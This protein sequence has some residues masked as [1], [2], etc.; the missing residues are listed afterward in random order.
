MAVKKKGQ[1][2]QSSEQI[3][4]R[5]SDLARGG[6]G[7]ARDSTGRVIFVP[8]TA[9]GDRVRVEL[10][11]LDKNYAQGKLLEII[12]PSPIR[13]E[14]RCPAFTQCG[15]CEWQHLHYDLQWKT[16]VNGILHALTRV[17]ITAPSPI[18]E[19]PA[20][21]IWEYRNRIQLRGFQKEMGF[22]ASGSHNIISLKRCDI[23][24]SEINEAWETIRTE[25]EKL[26]RPYKVEIETLSDGKSGIRQTWNSR[27]AASGFR[28]VHD[29]QNTQLQR[30]VGQWITPGRILFDLYGG[31][32]NLSTQISSK[33]IETHCVDLS[34]PDN[35]FQDKPTHYTFHRSAITSWLNKQV[36]ERAPAPSSAILDPPRE[37]LAADF[38]PIASALAQLG[39]TEAVLV[40]C[41][42]DAWARDLSRFLK[43]GWTLK[44]MAI[45]DLFPQTHHVE[46]IARIVL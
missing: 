21:Q 11:H 2:L 25:G 16:K 14:P 28:Q 18:E 29:Q 37:G 17:G 46:S 15:G 1:R 43:K 30:V 6:S 36:K 27:H 20:Q 44:A 5:I 38:A 10:T 22:Y 42:P 33:M 8:Y 26:P 31:S 19:V 40:G 4:L 23:A 35:D 45:L 32:G 7:V 9:P 13:Q 39:V 12:E 34:V 3:E 24:R 41:D